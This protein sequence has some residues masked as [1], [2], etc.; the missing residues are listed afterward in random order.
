VLL[1][2]VPVPER[3]CFAYALVGESLPPFRHVSSRD[4]DYE[5]LHLLSELDAGR[6]V[7]HSTGPLAPD[8]QAGLGLE[9]TV[10]YLARGGRMA[11]AEGEEPSSVRSMVYRGR[12]RR[13][14]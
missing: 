2:G 7:P 5:V 13:P 14:S 12:K 10:V 1:Q 8:F 9:Q 6:S 4:A 3:A 11:R